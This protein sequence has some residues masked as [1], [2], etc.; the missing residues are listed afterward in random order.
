MPAEIDA[1]AFA[2]L[3]DSAYVHAR[4]PLH[5]VAARPRGHGALRYRCPVTGSFVLLNGEA[6][7]KRLNRPQT[8]LRC[9]DCSELHL[10]TIA[11]DR[12]AAFATDD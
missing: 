8:R 12:L 7:L 1:S 9:P 11:V 6:T 2:T 4:A 3:H 10:M 5:P